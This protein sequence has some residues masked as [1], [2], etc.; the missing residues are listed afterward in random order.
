MTRRFVTVAQLREALENYDDDL[1]VRILHQPS[2][3]LQEVLGG[4]FQAPAGCVFDDECGLPSEHEVHDYGTGDEPIEG[5]H[6][7]EEPDDAGVV[8]LVANGHPSDGSPY[9]SKDAWD[10]MERL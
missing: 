3:P 8:F 6:A 1:E 2:W 4:L 10:G 7:F 9:G 5:H